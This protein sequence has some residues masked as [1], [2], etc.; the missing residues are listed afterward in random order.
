MREWIRE[1]IW[2]IFVA[3]GMLYMAI[4]M[5]LQSVSSFEPI[6][7]NMQSAS[8]VVERVEIRHTRFGSSIHFMIQGNTSTFIY[9]SF[10][11]NKWRAEQLIRT[12]IHVEA[13]FTG[14]ERPNIWSIRASGESLAT[15]LEISDSQKKNGLW[16]IAAFVFC[17]LISAYSLRM[18]YARYLNSR[19]YF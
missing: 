6:P 16:G 13:E 3:I 12:G 9:A 4:S 8:G 10:F 2:D 19:R 15:P 7:K 14:T 18:V 17:G 1:S 5:L 11:P